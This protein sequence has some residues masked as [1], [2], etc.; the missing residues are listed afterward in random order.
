MF[1]IVSKLVQGFLVPSHFILLVGLVGVLLLFS[2]WRRGGTGLCAASILMT[3][4]F[5]VSPLGDMALSTLEN[6]FPVPEL[7]TP[8]TGIIMLGGTTDLPVS[9]AR[10]TIAL[11]EAAERLTRTAMLAIRFPT[12]RIVLSGGVGDLINTQTVTESELGREFLVQLGIAENRI[13]IDEKSRT[14]AE[15]AEDSLAIIKPKPGETWL[16]VTSANHMPRAVGS[17]R[18]VGFNVVPYPVDFRTVGH[19]ID[20]SLGGG[21]VKLDVAAHEWIG[22]VAYWLTGRSTSLLPAP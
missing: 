5:S 12:A 2:P 3:L 14:T 11:G 8:P 9:S 7:V 15:N 16:L 10:H 13:A 22:L 18:A 6:R 17:F 4:F 21:L 19:G 1:F 20:W